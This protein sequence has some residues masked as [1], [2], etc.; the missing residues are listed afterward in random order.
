M[1]R[2]RDP[3]PEVKIVVS[4]NPLSFEETQKRVDKINDIF[5]DIAVRYHVEQWKKSKEG[6]QNNDKN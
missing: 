2:K 4:D 1:A 5:V 6:K 3:I